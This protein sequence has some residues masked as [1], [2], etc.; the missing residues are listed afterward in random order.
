MDKNGLP[1]EYD[2]IYTY[3][4]SSFFV[5]YLYFAKLKV[6]DLTK[7]LLELRGWESLFPWLELNIDLSIK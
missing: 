1:R 7:T 3:T 4:D 5:I 6:L 2:G